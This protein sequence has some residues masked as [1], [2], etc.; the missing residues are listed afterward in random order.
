MAAKRGGRREKEQSEDSV[1][2]EFGGDYSEESLNVL[3]SLG[4]KGQEF[5][6]LGSSE[7]EALEPPSQAACDAAV[8]RYKEYERDLQEVAQHVPDE[9]ERNWVEYKRALVE[10]ATA[11]ELTWLKLK[12]YHRGIDSL[13]AERGED[14]AGNPIDAMPATSGSASEQQ[15]TAAA[16]SSPS[17]F[18][19]RDAVLRA[20]RDLLPSSSSEEDD[21]ATTSGAGGW[22]PLHQQQRLAS[23][24]AAGPMAAAVTG[25]T[26][27]AAAAAAS[28]HPDAT[29]SALAADE[30]GTV[31]VS[32][33]LEEQDLSARVALQQRQRSR[34]FTIS[35]AAA[36]TLSLARWWLRRGR[37][38]RPDAAQAAAAAEQPAAQAQ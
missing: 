38:G 14:A 12:A 17:S 3:R 37:K 26:L 24:A 4:K 29:A 20:V 15:G 33:Y 21:T 22:G 27:P 1:E 2:A 25:A 30:P 13:R 18:P 9:R 36:L 31:Y 7:Q 19:E 23:H 5:A 10:D 11:E 35:L 16:S 34:A 28:S 8:A 32:S 6:E